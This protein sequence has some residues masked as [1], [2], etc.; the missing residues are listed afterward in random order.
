[1]LVQKISPLVQARLEQFA[2]DLV[3]EKYIQDSGKLNNEK[4]K[5]LKRGGF[6]DGKLQ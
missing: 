1:M 4:I 3:P 5:C 6:I 2:F